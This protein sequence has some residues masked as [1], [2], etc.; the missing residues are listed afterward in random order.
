MQGQCGGKA[1]GA[2]GH[3][4]FQRKA[5]RHGHQ[6]VGGQTGNFA[7]TAVELLADVATRHQHGITGFVAGVVAGDDVAGEINARRAWAAAQDLALAGDGE[8]VL[9]VDAAVGDADDDIAC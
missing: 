7:V 2:N 4:L 9:V 3:R 8:C 1:R 5:G 6:R